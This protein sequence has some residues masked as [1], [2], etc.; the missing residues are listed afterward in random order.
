MGWESVFLEH[1]GACK[2]D[3]TGLELYIP[4]GEWG[5]VMMRGDLISLRPYFYVL[6]LF[7]GFPIFQFATHPVGAITCSLLGRSRSSFRDE[8]FL[9]SGD[10]TSD[11]EISNS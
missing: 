11:I 6:F 4:S 10:R 3:G 7:L 5:F 2:I 9:L 1:F 8:R